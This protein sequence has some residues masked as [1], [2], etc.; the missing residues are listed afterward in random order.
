[1]KPNQFWTIIHSCGLYTKK[2]RLSIF[3]FL[4]EIDKKIKTGMIPVDSFLIDY[5][6]I[7]ILTRR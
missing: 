5:I 2:Q 4:T 6:V 3:N 1:M 7:N